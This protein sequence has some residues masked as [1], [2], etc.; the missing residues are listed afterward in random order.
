MNEEKIIGGSWLLILTTWIVEHQPILVG[1][2]TL[3]TIVLTC[4][5]AINYILK[6]RKGKF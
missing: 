6:W 3:L 1:V 4:M 2:S 5:G